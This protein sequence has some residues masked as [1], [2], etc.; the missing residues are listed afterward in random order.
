MLRTVFLRASLGALALVCAPA[1]HATTFPIG[2]MPNFYITSG[3]PFS[4]S[5]T[6]N[7]GNGFNTHRLFD[8]SFTFTIPFLSGVGSGSL[9]TSFSSP[10]NHLIINH[11]WIN[12][13]PY[14]VPITPSGQ[15]ITVGGI[16]IIAGVLNTI[17]LTGETGL[18]GG[19]YAGTATFAATSVPETASWLMLLGGFGLMG[20]MLRARKATAQFE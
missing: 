5:I 20:T 2:T 8:D 11:L 12:G 13:T 17:R 7:F 10:N 16:P 6:A 14:V 3:T 15:S 18:Q 1:A 4:S 19:S 9:S